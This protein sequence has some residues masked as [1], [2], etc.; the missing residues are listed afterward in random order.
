[1][2]ACMMWTIEPYPGFQISICAIIKCLFT[3]LNSIFWGIIRQC[4]HHANSLHMFIYFYQ[5]NVTVLLFIAVLFSVPPANYITV[6]K[7]RK[8][9]WLI[10]C[11]VKFFMP[12]SQYVFIVTARYE[13]HE[14]LYNFFYNFYSITQWWRYSKYYSTRTTDYK[15]LPSNWLTERGDKTNRFWARI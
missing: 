7:E 1:M 10:H 9:N 6:K 11:L 15:C 3:V 8:K 14:F 13:F 5:T 12:I 4:F 2:L